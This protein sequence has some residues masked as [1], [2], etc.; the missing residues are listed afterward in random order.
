MPT[1]LTSRPLPGVTVLTLNRPQALN[2]LTHTL[3]GELAE[4]LDDVHRDRDCRVLVLTGAGR[5][6]C[7]GLDLNGYGDARLAEEEG[8]VIRGL[9]RQREIAALAQRLHELRQPV[10][11]AVNGPAAGGGLALVCAS[12]I[13]IAATPAVFAVSFIRAG[14]S[15]CD[16]GVSWL[17]PRI[18]GAGR[19]HELMLTG[20]RFDAAEARAIGLVTDVSEPDELLAE[21]VRKAEEI[22]LNPPVS[23]ELTKQGMWLALETPSFDAAV[24]FENRQQLFTALTEDRA[25]ATAAFLEKRPPHYRRR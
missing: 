12:D 14:F 6:F 11:S 15:A 2:A 25:E 17:L 4:A 13:R 20:R 22:M 21:A 16:I 9:G 18:V 1:V 7:A 5:A 3:V 24:E 19:A 10:I 23:V 8:P